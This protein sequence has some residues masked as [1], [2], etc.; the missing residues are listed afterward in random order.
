MSFSASCYAGHSYAWSSDAEGFDRLVCR[1]LAVG[2]ANRALNL[3]LHA[4]AD[5]GPGVFDHG[6]ACGRVRVPLHE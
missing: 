4:E 3:L 1:L 2:A 6:L 5:R